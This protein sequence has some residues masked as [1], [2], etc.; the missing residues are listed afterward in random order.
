MPEYPR[1]DPPAYR[2][3][4][5]EALELALTEPFGVLLLVKQDVLRNPV[6]VARFGLGA[7]VAASA[8]ET[9]FVQ[10]AGAWSGDSDP[11]ILPPLKALGIL[12]NEAK[13][14]TG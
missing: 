5:E 11:M 14:Y 6:D 12:L 3:V 9:D 1:R 7:I 8:P 4:I 13:D 2:Q 10:Q